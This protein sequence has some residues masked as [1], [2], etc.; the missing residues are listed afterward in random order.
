MMRGLTF[1]SLVFTLVIPNL[2]PAVGYPERPIRWVLGF[3]P[4]GAPDA[5]ARIVSPQLSVQLGQSVV[6]DNRPGANGILGADLVAKANPDGYTML[7]TSASFAIN[8]STQKKLPFDPLTSFEPVTNL[9]S[10][11]ALLLAVS[12]SVP[13]T[14][15]KELIELAKR[16]GA[17]FAYGTSGVGNVTHLAAALFAA[18]TGTDLT[19]VPYKGGGPMTTALVSGEVQ[20]ALSNPGTLIGAVKA[21]RI[22]ALAYNGAKRSPLLPDVP[23]MIESGVAGMEL[24]PSWYG[25]FAP[26]KTPAAIVNRIHQEIRAALKVPAVRERL[27][28]INMQPVGD[29]PSEFR[30]F[31]ARAIKRYAELVKLAGIRPE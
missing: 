4:A 25:V 5:V 21:G 29:S 9:C 12:P 17:R 11:E 20:L 30:A 18:R 6:L 14:T 2:A 15:V 3:A 24:D 27:A 28:A 13:A 23:T 7:I 8:P 1:A 19:H 16:P 31:V 26:A 22:R 10:S